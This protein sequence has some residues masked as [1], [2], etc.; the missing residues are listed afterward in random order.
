MRDTDT[1]TYTVRGMSCEHCRL[2]V[3][4]GVSKLEGV[5]DV[6]VE[7]PT[8]R[9]EVRGRGI[10]DAAVEA[11]VEQAGYLLAGGERTQREM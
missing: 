5:E 8:G 6:S 3:S 4:E 1:R 11:A 9:L 10:R 7:L 2:A